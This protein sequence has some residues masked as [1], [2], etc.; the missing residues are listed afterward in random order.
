MCKSNPTRLCASKAKKDLERVK[1]LWLE[2]EKAPD[3]QE[4][5]KAL[6]DLKHAQKEFDETRGGQQILFNKIKE[7]TSESEKQ[8]LEQRKLNALLRRNA[9][10]HES[11]V[12]SGKK[13]VKCKMH[14]PHTD[15][16]FHKGQKDGFQPECKECRID[17]NRNYYDSPVGTN[18]SRKHISK[19]RRNLISEITEPILKNGCTDCGEYHK[20]AM[21]FDHVRGKKLYNISALA[22][23]NNS[24]EEMLSLLRD[25]LSKC[26]VRC[27][28]CH[29]IVTGERQKSNARLKFLNDPKSVKGKKNYLYHRLSK[30]KCVDCNSSDFRVLEYDHIRGSKKTGLSKMTA[31]SKWTLQDIDDE[32]KK[33]DVR[34]VNC[35]RKVTLNRANEESSEQLPKYKPTLEELTCSC[36]KKKRYGAKTCAECHGKS[37][38]DWPSAPKIVEL[39]KT[40]NFSSVAK[41]LGVSDNS[42]RAYLRRE[43]IDLKTIATLR[44]LK[45]VERICSCGKPKQ[46][47]SSKCSDCTGN[48]GNKLLDFSTEDLQKLVAEFGITRAA[49]KIG[50]HRSAVGRKL[51]LYKK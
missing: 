25:E 43:G 15:F 45:K 19:Q 11:V 39:L 34:C 35:H 28:N 18:R 29:R 6:A 2:V 14:K 23:L 8:R 27:A 32:I 48:K 44:D 17:V 33:C 20:G 46:A 38:K 37:T 51:G 5:E 10:E 1:K 50:V 3:S 22:T 9:K 36:G 24:D 26:E 13:C 40:S 42:V 30:E 16:A 41:S 21:D 12:R 7:S 4:K 31:E 49:D 47:Q